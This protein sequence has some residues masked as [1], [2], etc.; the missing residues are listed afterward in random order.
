MGARRS[1]LRH[2]LTAFFHSRSIRVQCL[3]AVQISYSLC[4]D[5]SMCH[6]GKR[7]TWQFFIWT[8]DDLHILW[9][10]FTTNPKLIITL[11]FC[12]PP[13][14]NPTFSILKTNKK[15]AGSHVYS[16]KCDVYL[17]NSA[18]GNWRVLHCTAKVLQ[19]DER[20]IRIS[21]RSLHLLRITVYHWT[22]HS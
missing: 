15:T 10:N 17:M 1:F 19:R 11:Q 6:G 8:A 20:F 22:D 5:L 14:L 9:K 4:C 3:A 21:L 18:I 2:F 12:N 16:N 7:K 13:S